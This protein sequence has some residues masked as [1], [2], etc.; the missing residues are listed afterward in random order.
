MNSIFQSLTLC[1]FLI[2]TTT[3]PILI[4]SFVTLLKTS[5]ILHIHFLHIEN[6]ENKNIF[7]KKNLQLHWHL[8]YDGLGAGEEGGPH[9]GDVERPLQPQHLQLLLCRRRC[10]AH[11]QVLKG[12]AS[13]LVFHRYFTTSMGAS[14][15][16]SLQTLYHS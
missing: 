10:T 9:G 4:I 11:H 16:R 8:W 5:R 6:I 14:D 1:Q 3:P 7:K 15:F 2:F 13:L 12:H